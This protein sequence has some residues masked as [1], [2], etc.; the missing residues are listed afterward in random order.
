MDF[1]ILVD[2]DIFYRK[3][4]KQTLNIHVINPYLST[5]GT[6]TALFELSI[7]YLLYRTVSIDVIHSDRTNPES[8]SPETA[9][10]SAGR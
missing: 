10:I 5:C 1:L 4:Y 7:G 2:I 3:L 8:R 6:L 9:L